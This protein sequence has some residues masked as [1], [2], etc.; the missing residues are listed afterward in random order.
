MEITLRVDYNPATRT[1]KL[2]D[3]PADLPDLRKIYFGTKKKLES[4]QR[5]YMQSGYSSGSHT[6]FEGE[7]SIYASL[8]PK[9][10]EQGYTTTIHT[11]VLLEID[12]TDFNAK[13]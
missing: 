5:W 11:A 3:N 2:L 12:Q 9:R 6:F 7:R 13:E 10:V 8:H 1:F 4:D